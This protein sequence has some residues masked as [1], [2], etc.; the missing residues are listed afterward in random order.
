MVKIVS[1]RQKL[2]EL[3]K[4]YKIHKI[5]DQNI[6]LTTYDIEIILLKNNIGLP[7]NNRGY[8]SHKIINEV[9]KPFYEVLRKKLSFNI[10][11][12]YKIL[13]EELIKKQFFNINKKLKTFFEELIKKISTNIN[14]YLKN[15]FRG[16]EDY[17]KFIILNI[18][19]FFKILSRTI[20][21]GL[22]D[23]YEFRVKEKL[24]RNFLSKGVYASLVVALV[25][26]GLYIK[27]V[28]MDMDSVKISLEIRSD[29]KKNLKELKRKEVVKTQDNINKDK[30]KN[31]AKLSKDKESSSS[32]NDYNLNTQTVLTLFEDLEY[33]LDY[34]RKK[35]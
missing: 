34:V 7:S 9:F 26:S 1:Y 20:V 22:N 29:K 23:I 28:I 21:D 24:I 30:T 5:F 31:L 2:I 27:D 15:F 12:E 32:D 6:K 25:F 19:N 18:V 14:K 35:K 10:I 16:I 3:A 13:L 4:I 8:V 33:D 11:K 17:F